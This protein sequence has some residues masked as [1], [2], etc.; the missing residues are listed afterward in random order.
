MSDREVMV[1]AECRD[2][3]VADVSLELISKAA[4]LAGKLGAR[5][6]AVMAGDGITSLAREAIAYGC[7]VVC[8]ADRPELKNYCTTAYAAVVCD[9]IEKRSP[10]IVIY[11]ATPQGR[12]LAPRVASALK[13][14]LTADCTALD[15]DDWKDPSC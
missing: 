10:E 3:A 14:G 13:A 2:G 9:F 12:D 15:I 7:D 5:V 6:S 8:V 1:Y 11:G 4:E